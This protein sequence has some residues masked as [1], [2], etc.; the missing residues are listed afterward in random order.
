MGRLRAACRGTAR[1]AITATKTDSFPDPGGDGKAEPGQTITYTVQITNNG[2][3]AATG[4]TFT[5]LIGAN[6][7]LVPGSVDAT[8]V[9]IDDTYAAVGNVR[10]SVADGAGDLLSNDCNPDAGVCNGTG[11]TASG[12]T[13]STS[14]GNV[15]VNADGSF[16]YNPPPGFTGTDTFTYTITDG[17]T[18][19][20]EGTVTINVANMIW[21][22]K[23]GAAAGGDGRLTSPFNCY[24]GAS[25]PGVQ[26][27]FSDTAADEA[28]DNIFLYSGSYTG[29]NTLLNN[30]RLIGQGATATLASITSVT[31]PT[32]SDALP[33]TGGTSPALTTSAAATNAVTLGQGNTLRGFSVGNTTGAKIF[34]NNFG[35]LTVGNSVTPDVSLGGN[36]QALNLTNGTFAATSGF[37][38][39]ATTSSAA[40]GILLSQVAGTVAFG[41]TSVSGSATQGVSVG[42]STANINFGNT[43][44]TGGTDAISLAEQLGGHAHLRRHH[45]LGQQRRRIPARQRRRRRQRHRRDHHHQPGGRRHQR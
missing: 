4:V 23:S 26:T 44:V 11:L 28:G 21:F 5:D 35:T 12:P 45:D 38:G 36:G 1:P 24:T 29:G 42:S 32:H 22:V 3:D 34:G 9:A 13:T 2:A 33:S 17:Q 15:T 7:T 43:S 6:I 39:V 27:C 30:Q 14:G 18:Q 37:N 20:D 10:I 16:T 19:T 41:S 31:V 8:P 25:A 40:Q